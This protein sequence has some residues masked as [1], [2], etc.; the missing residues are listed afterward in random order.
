MELKKQKN[1]FNIS[2]AINQYNNSKSVNIRNNTSK[3]S[4]LDNK[5]E[6]IG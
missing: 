2:Q 5:K 6:I 3:N 1:E 4:D